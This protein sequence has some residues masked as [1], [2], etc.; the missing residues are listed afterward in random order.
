MS[1]SQPPEEGYPATRSFLGGYV[2]SWNI[3]A[4]T[5]F[6][7]HIIPLYLQYSCT[8]YWCLWHIKTYV[9]SCAC[10]F[11]QVTKDSQ[12]KE[13]K[14]DRKENYPSNSRIRDCHRHNYLVWIW[15]RKH[16]RINTAKLM[17]SAKMLL[18][19][20]RYG[21]SNFWLSFVN[22][23]KFEDG[24]THI[25]SLVGNPHWMIPGMLPRR[26]FDAAKVSIPSQLKSM[27]HLWSL[28]S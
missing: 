22:V 17:S 26:N 23:N 2:N 11:Q 18:T 3:D 14:K 16:Q 8:I 20:G 21:A 25:G 4:Y 5:H 19:T 15:A 24:K 6:S 10:E 12:E 1:P 9:P 13:T 7:K 27:Y 28:T